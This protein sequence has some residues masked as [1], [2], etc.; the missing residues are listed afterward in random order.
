MAAA[1]PLFQS[2]IDVCDVKKE[3]KA[4][5]APAIIKKQLPKTVKA[6][7]KPVTARVFQDKMELTS[8]DKKKKVPIDVVKYDKI[9]KVSKG[10]KQDKTAV[11]TYEGDKKKPVWLV[12]LRFNTDKGYEEFLKVVNKENKPE[13]AQEQQQPA[14]SPTPPTPKPQPPASVPP[15]Q[16]AQPQASRDF[17]RRSSSATNDKGQSTSRPAGSATALSRR[18]ISAT[19]STQSLTPINQYSPPPPTPVQQTQQPSRRRSSSS[20]SSSSSAP[21]QQSST[22]QSRPSS[23]Q[24][25]SQ[26]ERPQSAR[27]RASSSS[28]SSSSS[29]LSSAFTSSSTRRTSAGR[30]SRGSTS[31]DRNKALTKTTYVEYPVTKSEMQSPQA[32]YLNESS[33]KPSRSRAYETTFFTNTADG[34][35]SGQT[36]RSRS[37]E[38]KTPQSSMKSKMPTHAPVRVF[39]YIPGK[40]V[41]KSERGKMFYYSSDTEF[42]GRGRRRRNTSTSSSDSSSSDTVTAQNRSRQSRRDQSGK[43]SMSAGRGHNTDNFKGRSGSNLVGYQPKRRQ[44]V[45]FDTI[46]SS[47][48]SSSTNSSSDSGHSSDWQRG[49]DQGGRTRGS[50]RDQKPRDS[51]ESSI[52]SSSDISKEYF[53]VVPQKT[54]SKSSGFPRGSGIRRL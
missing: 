5:K 24:Q 32:Q 14:P 33:K 36:G 43:R 35:L 6:K 13:A 51:S 42:G 54:K 21:R 26:V 37:H 50:R 40:G 19:S 52:S 34:G 47:S 12:F 23:R 11:L 2:K 41:V 16:P 25:P 30:S 22:K 49:N 46:C 7:P 4:D 9:Q 39:K 38:S 18:S 1:K 48:S 15:Q 28:S 10:P 53:A 20:S 27:R 45:G 3:K 31:Q 44:E 17:S 8:A 29:S